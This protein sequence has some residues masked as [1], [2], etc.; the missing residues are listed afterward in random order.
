MAIVVDQ[1]AATISRR[2]RAASSVELGL[3]LLGEGTVEGDWMDPVVGLKG[4]RTQVAVLQIQDGHE[5]L[6]LMTF[7]TPPAR[8]SRGPVAFRARARVRRRMPRLSYLQLAHNERHPAWVLLASGAPLKWPVSHLA[9]VPGATIAARP[10]V[11]PPSFDVA[12]SRSR[13]AP[14]SPRFP[15]EWPMYPM[16]AVWN[17][18]LM[19][20]AGSVL[21][22]ESL[23]G[24]WLSVD[25][26]PTSKDV[27]VPR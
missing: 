25:A 7:H 9:P 19:A 1:L 22:S 11:R 27:N 13:R 4:V 18:E 14:T 20:G 23:F 21:L 5:R 8:G 12:T 15:P 17:L 6:E 10:Q 16:C 24:S 26:A 3:Q 2:R